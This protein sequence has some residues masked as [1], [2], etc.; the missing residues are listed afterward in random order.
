MLCEALVRPT[1]VLG[2]I[3]TVET[4]TGTTEIGR[5]I[6]T[7]GL[8]SRL[9]E[10]AS[11]SLSQRTATRHEGFVTIVE[12]PPLGATRSPRGAAVLFS[13]PVQCPRELPHLRARLR[14]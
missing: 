12:I 8:P 9:L 4:S 7:S 14:A 3:V 1:Q 10:V 2:V 13:I 6:Q 11:V 5:K